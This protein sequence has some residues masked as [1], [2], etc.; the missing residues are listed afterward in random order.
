MNYLK[1]H[2]QDNVHLLLVAPQ[3]IRKRIFEE[4]NCQKYSGHLLGRD[5]VCKSVK[6]RFYWIGKDSDVGRWCKE[7]DNCARGKP[8]SGFTKSLLQQSLV[9]WPLDKIGIDIAGP[10]PITDNEYIIVLSG[11]FFKMS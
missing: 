10:C 2:K 9:C 3:I 6:E 5:R 8:G 11:F 1:W 4:L 7:C